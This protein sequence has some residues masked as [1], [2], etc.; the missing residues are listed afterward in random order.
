MDLNCQGGDDDA[1]AVLDGLDLV[2]NEIKWRKES[3]KLLYHLLDDPAH[4]KELNGGVN[5]K[6]EGGCSCGKK[7]NK[8]L[9]WIKSIGID[10]KI[11]AANN[12]VKEKLKGMIDKFNAIINVDVLDAKI[13]IDIN[14]EC[15]QREDQKQEKVDH[16]GIEDEDQ[17]IS[18]HIE[19]ESKVE[20]RNDDEDNYEGDFEEDD[21][22]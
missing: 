4:G 19:K 1:E 3:F 7:Y 15:R 2:I 9:Y 16:N 8:I 10:Y 11:V 22:Y 17:L 21:N 18:E 20:E 5:D 12:T 14:V 13:D 6:Y